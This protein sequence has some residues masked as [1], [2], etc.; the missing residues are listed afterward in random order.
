MKPIRWER[1]PHLSEQAQKWLTIG[2]M[3]GLAAN[4]I[5]AYGRSLEEFFN[6]CEQGQVE[7]HQAKREHIARYVQDMAV[8]P[9]HQPGQVGLANATMQQRLTALRLF[10]DFLV[11]EG[12]RERNPVGRGRYV[13]GKNYARVG[14]RGLIPHYRRLPWIPGEE[15]WHAILEATRQEPLRNRL[16]LAMAYD[17]ALRREELC[18]LATGDIDPAHRLLHIRAETTKTRQA[19]VVP[20]SLVTSDLLVS[21]LRERRTLSRERGALFLS[22]SR[23]NRAQPI[24]IWTWSKVVRRIALRADVPQFTPHTLRHLCLTDLARA[25]WDLH[26]IAQF[27]GHRTTQTTLLYIHLS[28][29]E[30]AQKV[31]SGMDSIHQWRITMVENLLS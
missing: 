17:S 15:A 4:T 27:A 9:R 8:R 7:V 6:F 1:Y 23:R 21:Y 11:E 22:G 16:M 12:W 20:Y 19:R 28:G 25:N 24:S 5:E 3:L 14:D 13:P 2:A 29:R 31:A 26:E 30:L 18:A 10:Y